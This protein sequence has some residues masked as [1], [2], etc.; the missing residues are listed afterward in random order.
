MRQA[1]RIIRSRMPHRFVLCMLALLTVSRTV[2]DSITCCLLLHLHQ[3]SSPPVPPLEHRQQRRHKPQDTNQAVDDGIIETRNSSRGREGSRVNRSFYW[4]TERD[5]DLGTDTFSAAWYMSRRSFMGVD[6]SLIKSLEGACFAVYWDRGGAVRMPLDYLD[7]AVEHGSQWWRTMGSPQDSEAASVTASTYQAFVRR[8][9]HGRSIME[10]QPTAILKPT[11]AVVAFSQNTLYP[12]DPATTAERTKVHE[13]EVT[14]FSLAATLAS[15][16]RIGLGRILVVGHADHDAAAV[17][18]AFRFLDQ[19]D[20][21]I[22]RDSIQS[23]APK[24]NVL[25]TSL[26]Y[27]RPTPEMMMNGGDDVQENVPKGAIAGLQHALT[28]RDEAWTQTWLGKNKSAE[29]WQYVYY[30]EQDSVLQTRP[31]ALLH[32]RDALDRGLIVLPHRLQ[33]IPHQAD[34]P[35]AARSGSFVSLDDLKSP[36]WVDSH[37]HCCDSQERRMYQPDLPGYEPC[38]A[39]WWQCGFSDTNGQL[40]NHSRLARYDLMRLADG[41]GIATIAGSSHGRRC[42]ISREPCKYRD[43][44]ESSTATSIH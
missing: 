42:L 12:L 10:A 9:L 24:A 40:G 21:A 20:D 17:A 13:R 22:D 6:V 25:G 33:P 38:G 29:D 14:V 35:R 36:T 7:F 1:T 4:L 34:A 31:T 18:E 11:I 16:I 32:L 27:V 19:A 28:G 15:L 2:L 3:E 8:H 37:G 41:T 5:I 30:T 39:P 43:Q 26:A 23:S 44:G